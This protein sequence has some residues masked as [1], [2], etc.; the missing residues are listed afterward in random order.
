MNQKFFASLTGKLRALVLLFVLFGAAQQLSA[1]SLVSPTTA[2]SRLKTQQ[3]AIEAQ[4]IRDVDSKTITQTQ[5]GLQYLR[6]EYCILVKDR[7]IG[8]GV[9]TQEALDKG[10]L[11]LVEQFSKLPNTNVTLTSGHVQTVVSETTGILF[12]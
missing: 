1:Q 11:L 8:G 5:L 6:V 7:L 12:N 2:I 10:A 9:T 4:L 3:Y